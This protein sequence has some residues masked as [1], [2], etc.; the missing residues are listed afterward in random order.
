M[1]RILLSILSMFLLMMSLSAQR[2]DSTRRIPG[3]P[4]GGN[5]NGPK[6]YRE[7]ITSKAVSDPGLFTV[8]KLDDKYFVEIPDSILGR[9][10]LVVNRISKASAGMRSQGSF[11]GY[12]GDQIGSN[13]I[14]FERGP[15]NK[16][17]IRS[18]SYAEYAKD[19]SSPMF[20]AVTNSNV[21]Q[22][23][24]AFDLK[25]LGKDSS[26]VVIDMTE[27]FNGDND[28]LF[29]GPGAKSA[30]RLGGLQPDKS[31][32][33]SVR[34]FPINM[35]LKTVKTYSRAVA[36]GTATSGGAAPSGNM[37]MELNSSIVLLPK[38]PMQSR[39]YDPRVGYF[40]V[41]YNDFDANPQGVKQINMVKRWRLEPK[42]GDWEKYMRGE[43]V[44]PQKPIIF[45]I[46]PA[47]PKKWVPYLI[48]G[49][50]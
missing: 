44:E 10:L 28:I 48:Q 11:F 2:T 29:F 24:A 46:D 35:E 4:G 23:A 16:V 37:T 22:I 50:E 27:Y 31:Y 18:I 17:F 13:V 25:S 33:N 39:L 36:M 30:L 49:G 41:G 42:A 14:R 32:I 9:E 1:Q 26:G 21:Q 15:N 45:Y 34:S 47:T 8:H 3:G 38:V 40:Y 19:S 5:G 43:L 7:V 20:T 12:G 6:P